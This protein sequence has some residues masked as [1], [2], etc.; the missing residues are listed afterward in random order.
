LGIS[1]PRPAEFVTGIADG[2]HNRCDAWNHRVVDF[3]GPRIVSAAGTTG[4]RHRS[5]SR[6]RRPRFGG[7]GVEATAGWMR[8]SDQRPA[9]WL[10]ARSAQAERRERRKN[11]PRADDG[12]VFL[13][14]CGNWTPYP[15]SGSRRD[16]SQNSEDGWRAQRAG[17]SCGG[18]GWG[19]R[20]G[21]E[22]LGKSSAAFFFAEASRSCRR[23]IRSRA[24][25]H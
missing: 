24:A 11:L 14:I 7:W 1:T 12:E 15:R 10:S 20:G 8:G 3:E 18:T 9:I 2:N 13:I 25:A 6:S 17:G 19:G 23:L 4:L 21:S 22:E 16:Y 5:C